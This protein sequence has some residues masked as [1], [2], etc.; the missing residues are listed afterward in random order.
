[1]KSIKKFYVV[2]IGLPGMGKTTL[3]KFLMNSKN[4]S[5]S[6]PAVPQQFGQ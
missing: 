3:S 4:Y 2:P 1:M 5:V 6:Y